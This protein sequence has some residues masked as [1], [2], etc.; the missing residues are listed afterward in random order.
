MPDDAL[1]PMAND[2]GWPHIATDLRAENA[3][4]CAEIERLRL[5]NW[6]LKGALGY[7]VPGDIPQGDYKCGMCLARAASEGTIAPAANYS[8][9]LKED[10]PMGND[11][12]PK[13]GDQPPDPNKPAPTPT[14][15]PNQPR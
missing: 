14:P 10:A 2:I 6:Q 11:P 5:E 7:S 13:P 9:H 3:K 15:N 12:N 1:N 8:A 4:L